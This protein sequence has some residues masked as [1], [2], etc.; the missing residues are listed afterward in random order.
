MKIIRLIEQKL[1]RFLWCGKDTKAKA[2]VSQA[3]VCFPKKEG[4]LGIKQLE[5]WNRAAMLSHIW[6]LFARAGSLWVAWVETIWPKGRSFWHIPIPSSCSWCWKK[7]LKLRVVAKQLIRFSIGKESRVFLWWDSWHPDGCLLAKYGHRAM[8][9]AGSNMGARVSSIIRDVQW[10]WPAARSESI[11]QIQSRLPE[12]LICEADQPIWSSKK[13][14]YSCAETWEFLREK[15]PIIPWFNLVWFPMAIPSHSFML[16]LVFRGAIVTKVKMSGWGYGR[17]TLCRFYY[18]KQESLE[19]F[20]SCNFSRRVWRAVMADCMI[21][22]AIEW[23]EV[24]RW[25]VSSLTGGSLWVNLCK[26]CL[27]A[28][29]YHLWKLRN[30]LCHCN[31]PRTEEAVVK[32][33]KWEVRTRI[34]AKGKFKLSRQNANLVQM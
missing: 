4:G 6:N 5:V 22:P 33:M 19:H 18:G 16:L 20:F 10:Y 7:S 34:M 21:N 27:A 24:E 1:N 31:T 11:V 3:N 2:K 14:T 9:D 23:E 32:Q 30:D 28:S 15:K 25:S 29:V 13:G 12:V 26:L 17:D 8:Y